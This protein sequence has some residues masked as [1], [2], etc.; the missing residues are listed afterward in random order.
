MPGEDLCGDQLG[1]FSSRQRLRLA[2][3]D[4]L[5]H[6]ADAHRAAACAMRVIADAPE[7]DLPELFARCDR[8]LLG[9]RGAALAVVDVE[10]H[11]ERI[12]HASVGNVRSV[13]L[14]R[15]RG[16]VKRLSGARGIVGAGFRGLR[17]E[18]VPLRRGD[19]VLLFSDG[20]PENADFASALTSAVP[21]D[22]LADDLLARWA[23]PRD[24]A[25]LILYRHD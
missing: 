24:D 22:A 6:G 15:Q 9:T 4:G 7:L 12:I 16:R 20:I 8:A 5:G 14:Q 18:S 10:R 11:A 25:S 2:V 17:P 1:C 21:D 23:S 19:W 13:L 3:A